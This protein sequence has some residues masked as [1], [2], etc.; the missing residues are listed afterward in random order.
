MQVQRGLGASKLALPS[1]GGTINVLTR[2]LEA[3]RG[4]SVQQNYSS[5]NVS[6]TTLS[7]TTGRMKGDWGITF[8]GSYKVGDGLVDET[9]TKAWFYFAKIEKQ[10]GKHIIGLSAVGAPQEHGQRSFKQPI[11][12]YDKEYAADLGVD[13]TSIPSGTFG[14]R[15]YA[16]SRS[17]KGYFGN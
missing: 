9:W 4:F 6:Q 11:A 10:W 15:R 7:G 16:F 13:T 3:K 5:G 8:T 2:G 1:V 12:K 17:R 14:N